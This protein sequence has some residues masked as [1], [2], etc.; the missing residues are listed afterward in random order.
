MTF[1]HVY[2]WIYHTNV[3]WN[4]NSSQ[5]RNINIASGVITSKG[6]RLTFDLSNKRIVNNVNNVRIQ[7]ILLFNYY[8][9]LK[10]MIINIV[11]VLTIRFFTFST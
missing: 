7:N 10:Q 6:R 9:K 5:I 4:E 8:L 3:F 1:Y 11:V 2:I